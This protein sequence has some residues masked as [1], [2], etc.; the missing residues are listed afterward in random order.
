MTRAV[1]ALLVSVSMLGCFP[2]NEKH[3]TYAKLVEGGAIVGGIAI[4]AFSNTGADCNKMAMTGAGTGDDTSCR[5]T[6]KLLS[7]VGV[8]LILGGLLG[9]VATVSTAEEE[10]LPKPVVTTTPDPKSAEPKTAAPKKDETK[11]ADGA[12]SPEPAAST[13]AAP[14]LQF[15]R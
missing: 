9:F 11:P 10:E 4:S 5:S 12:G 3:R 13:P 8:A 15:T 7:T 6:A 1:V 2:H 14:Q